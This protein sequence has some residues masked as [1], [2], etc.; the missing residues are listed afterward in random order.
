M[1]ASQIA[2]PEGPDIYLDCRKVALD[3]IGGQAFR[4]HRLLPNASIT[5]F[6]RACLR[7]KIA[8]DNNRRG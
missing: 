8:S 5:K 1:E 6:G 3:G 2:F 4:P 7:E